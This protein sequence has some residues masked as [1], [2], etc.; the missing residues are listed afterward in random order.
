[1]RAAQA[2]NRE[3]YTTL[4]SEVTPLIRQTVR[5]KRQFLPAADIEDIVQDTLL[6]LH[7]VRAT[8]DPERP[9]LPWLMAIAYNRMAD[10]SRRQLRERAREIQTEADV[11]TFSPAATNT[12][13]ELLGNRQLLN[14]ALGRLPAGQRRAVELLK[15]KELSLAEASVQSGM[16]IPALKVAMHRA[17]KTLRMIIQE[18]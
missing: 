16:S 14:Q 12:T 9:F 1:M 10:S 13:E 5:R 11:E 2:G 7:S 6:S 3:N 4:L 17:L 15:L 8:Y 18:T